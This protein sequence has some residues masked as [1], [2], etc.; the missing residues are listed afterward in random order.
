MQDCRGATE[1]WVQGDILIDWYLPEGKWEGRVLPVP[2][3]VL[4]R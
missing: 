2:S 1:L 3:Q 4:Q